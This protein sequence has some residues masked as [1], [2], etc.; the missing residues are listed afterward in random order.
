MS[1]GLTDSSSVCNEE[2]IN[3]YQAWINAAL[4]LTPEQTVQA[5]INLTT[6]ED[7][8]EWANS[9]SVRRATGILQTYWDLL[10]H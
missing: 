6:R 3:L 9:K 8:L 5:G 2:F 4:K 7:W 1:G 10:R